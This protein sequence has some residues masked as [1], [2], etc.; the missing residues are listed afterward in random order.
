MNRS[1][2]AYCLSVAYLVPCTGRFC[3]GVPFS[4][5]IFT[6]HVDKYLE[7]ILSYLQT[8]VIMILLLHSSSSDAI[9]G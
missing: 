4:Q 6:R 5:A 8:P 1:I 3:C 9:D 7:L 2:I